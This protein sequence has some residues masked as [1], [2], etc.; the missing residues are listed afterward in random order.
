MIPQCAV[1][2]GA[3]LTVVIHGLSAMKGAVT[4]PAILVRHLPVPFLRTQFIS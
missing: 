1:E 3:V 4:V 2:Q